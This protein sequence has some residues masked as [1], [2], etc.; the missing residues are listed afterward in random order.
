MTN[1]EIWNDSFRSMSKDAPG[2]MDKLDA[3]IRRRKDAG[4]SPITRQRRLRA[5]NLRC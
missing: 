4:F 1:L 5:S 2:S 3:T